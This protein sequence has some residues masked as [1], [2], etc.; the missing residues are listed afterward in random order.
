MKS[1]ITKFK[2]LFRS[3]IQLRYYLVVIMILLKAK[4]QW[5]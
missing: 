5:N 1:T 3:V 2:S 4:N